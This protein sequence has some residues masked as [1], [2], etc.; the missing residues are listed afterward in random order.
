MAQ[1]LAENSFRALVDLDNWESLEA[2][3]ETCDQRLLEDIKANLERRKQL[4]EVLL[5]DPN[6]KKRVKTLTPELQ[7]WAKEQLFGGNVCAVDGTLSIVP[8]TSGGR[9]RIGVVATSYKSDKIERVVYVS[10]R[11]LAGPA[12]SPTEYFKKLKSVNTWSGLFMRAVM[13]YAERDLALRRPEQWKFVHGELIPYELRTG[14]G[15]TRALPQCLSLGAKLVESK[16]AVGVV[17]GSEDIDLLN[18]VEMLDRFDYVEARGL[19]HELTE[20]LKGSPDP[21]NPGERLRGAHFNPEDHKRFEEFIAQHARQIKIGIFKVGL[22]PFIFHAHADNFDQAAALVMVDASMQALRGFPLLL[23]YA[24]HI[25]SQHLASSEFEKQ[26]HFK[27]A[28][29]GMEALGYEIDP[30]KTRRR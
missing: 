4:R 26:I 20:Y 3:L 17:E 25:C 8:S 5:S 12:S 15:R 9:A 23:D 16:T 13:A 10:Y 19:D 14:L 30:R 27:T 18:A 28:R 11:Q 1:D 21:D 22:K 2:Y 6:F 7:A 24:D 29:F